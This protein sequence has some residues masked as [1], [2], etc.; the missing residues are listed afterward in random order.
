MDNFLKKYTRF[1][2]KDIYINNTLY[3][4][5]LNQY[6]YLYQELSK[7]SILFRENIKYK[8]IMNIKKNEDNLLKL[9]NKKYLKKATLEYY[10]FFQRLGYNK[11]LDNNKKA[12][13]LADEENLLVVGKKR[14]EELIVGKIKYLLDYSKI[15]K[16][17]ILILESTPSSKLDNELTDKNIEI[18]CISIDYYK[19]KMLN[20]VKIIK[21]KEKY[22]AL[23]NYLIKYIK[24]FLIIYI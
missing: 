17:N 20:D 7:N 3:N 23:S 1:M 2:T 9:H 15:Y 6:N 24:L 13:I 11:I 8:K 5:F 16:K 14:T 21:D 22:S 12:I 19:E 10:E 4:N 18:D